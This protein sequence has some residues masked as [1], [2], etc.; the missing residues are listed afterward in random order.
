[1]RGP[2]GDGH[3][4]TVQAAVEGGDE[5]HSWGHSQRVSR[6][7]QLSLVCA[8]EEP[9]AARSVCRATTRANSNA[10]LGKDTAPPAG[11]LPTQRQAGLGASEETSGA[12]CQV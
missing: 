6:L 7:A 5:V 10:L 3:A 1:M 2:H 4:A 8:V 11:G 9:G 12:H